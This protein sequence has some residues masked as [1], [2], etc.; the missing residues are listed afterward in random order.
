[1]SKICDTWCQVV[2][3]KGYISLVTRNIWRTVILHL[4]I[5]FKGCFILWLLSFEYILPVFWKIAIPGVSELVGQLKAI[6]W[7]A[8]GLSAS[9]WGEWILWKEGKA[10]GPKW[11]PLKWWCERLWGTVWFAGER[12]EN[13]LLKCYKEYRLWEGYRCAFWKDP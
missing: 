12:N 10:F 4:P 7:S 1:M 13:D 9:L 8:C 6:N 3:L 11:W 2:S 5:Y